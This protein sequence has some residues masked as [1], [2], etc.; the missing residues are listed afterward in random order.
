MLKEG[1][2]EDMR[3]SR[4]AS[5]SSLRFASTT[6]AADAQTVGLADYVGRMKE[7]QD[8]IYYVTADSYAAAT[9]SPHLE[10]F[11]KKGVEVLLLYRPHRRV[12]AVGTDRIR[13]QAAACRWPRATLDLGKL[14]DEA[15]KK[16]AGRGSRSAVQ[17]AGRAA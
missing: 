7:G 13:G 5:R 4:T 2:V 3:Q 9:N 11:R 12:D 16:A 6:T 8:A 14:E 15:E 10:I 17:A 1:F